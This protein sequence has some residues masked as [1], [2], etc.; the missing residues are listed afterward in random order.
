MSYHSITVEGTSIDMTERLVMESL[1]RS[2]NPM[3]QGQADIVKLCWTIFNT[4]ENKI[5]REKLRKLRLMYGDRQEK[6]F[7]D[8]VLRPL[9]GKEANNTWSYDIMPVKPLINTMNIVKRVVDKQ[10]TLYDAPPG[11]TLDD[12]ASDAKYKELAKE[13][14]LD[15]IMQAFE[16]FQ[17]RDKTCFLRPTVRDE[18]IDIDILTP[19]IFYPIVDSDNTSKM[20]ACFW[21]VQSPYKEDDAKFAVWY[22]LNS[23]TFFSFH[24][25]DGTAV[26]IRGTEDMPGS[27][28]IDDEMEDGKEVYIPKKNMGILW[29]ATDKTNELIAYPGDSLISLQNNLNILSTLMNNS[30]IYQGFPILH[31]HGMDNTDP[32]TGEKRTIK[33]SPW[34]AIV[35]EGRPSEE[36]PSVEFVAPQTKIAEFTTAIDRNLDTYLLSAGIP[37]NLIIDAATS[38][39]AL[40]ERNRDIIE[41]RKSKLPQYKQIEQDLYTLIAQISKATNISGYSSLN[42]KAVLSIEYFE[43]EVNTLTELEQ[44]QVDRAKIDQGQLSPLMIFMRDHP[45]MDEAEAQKEL[46]KIKATKPANI[47]DNVRATA[48]NVIANALNARPNQSSIQE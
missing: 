25:M 37:K 42:E 5:R 43:P 28:Q 44:T 38:G 7:V 27:V 2:Y 14:G 31:I 17:V 48:S 33:T 8:E 24:M 26:K 40:A 9:M 20:K 46:D 1:A 47:F 32:Q 3:A 13:I 6:L 30:L 10:A 36:K 23:D 21:V 12:E 35:T 15:Y 29:A 11:R 34:S 18:G 39:T 41:I 4:P 45:D 22:Y 19:E 16:R